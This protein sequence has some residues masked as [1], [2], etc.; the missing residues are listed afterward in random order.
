MY[1][2]FKK[3]DIKLLY[4]LLNHQKV[5]PLLASPKAQDL[6]LLVVLEAAGKQP[7]HNPSINFNVM[8]FCVIL[9]HI[10]TLFLNLIQSLCCIQGQ[11]NR[12]LTNNSKISPQQLLPF[13]LLTHFSLVIANITLLK[14]QKFKWK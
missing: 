9:T 1:Q 6:S 11:G 7:I 5:R 2:R 4:T 3:K 13:P 8:F 12:I 10:H 14:Y